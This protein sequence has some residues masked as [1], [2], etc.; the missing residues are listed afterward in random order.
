MDSYWNT[1]ETA[2]RPRAGH[3]NR[4]GKVPKAK[5]S[6]IEEPETTMDEH[7]I[8]E[9]SMEEEVGDKALV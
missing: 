8:Y 1:P 2:Y 6:Q 5:Q 7:K 4:G 3:K 9:T